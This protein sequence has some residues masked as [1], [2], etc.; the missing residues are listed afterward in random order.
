MAKNRSGIGHPGIKM[1]ITLA[2]AFQMHVLLK[3]AVKGSGGWAWQHEK[4]TRAGRPE[5][6]ETA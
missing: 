1:R 2:R 6:A 3:T 4:S 5:A